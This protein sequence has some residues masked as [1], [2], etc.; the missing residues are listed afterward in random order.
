MRAPSPLRRVAGTTILS[1]AL[2]L[3]IA[4]PSNGAPSTSPV[5]P[6]SPRGAAHVSDTFSRA[7]AALRQAAA[8]ARSARAAASAADRSARVAERRAARLRTAAARQAASLS[9]KRAD[10]LARSARIAADRA[11]HA[12]AVA[13]G[14][15]RPS[16]GSLPVIPAAALPSVDA[17][18]PVVP[19]PPPGVLPP[20]APE[21]APTSMPTSTATAT[22][23]A[24]PSASPPAAPAQPAPTVGVSVLAFGAVGDG[25]ADDTAAVQRALDA[26]RPGVAVVVPAGRVFVHTDVL[27]VRVPGT[28]VTG[29]GVLLAT[30][31]DRSSVW[32]EADGVTLDGLTV[33]T[34]GTTRRW[35]AWEQMGLRLAGHSGAVVREVT[36]EGSAAAG[37]YVG[38]ADH[39]L[40]DHVTVQ[41]TRADGIHLTEGSHDGLVLAPTVVGSGDDG[42]AV[43]SY[44]SDGAPCHDIVVRSPQVLGTTWGRGLSVVGGTDVAFT[45]V[46]VQRSDAAAVYLGSEGQ[47]WNTWAPVRVSVTGG[48][49]QDSN[50]DQRID[51]GAVLVLAGGDGAPA[52][53]TV[54]VRGL[55]ISGTRR[56]ASRSAG[57]ISYGAAPQRVLLDQLAITGGPGDPVNGNTG[58]YTSTAI[59]KDGRTM[60]DHRG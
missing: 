47:P 56:T 10:A 15:R 34:Q 5:S 32:V 57:V 35:E 7:D 28:V 43:V 48:R 39:F 49:L 21:P 55:S 2:L 13:A 37:L 31:E 12:A 52:P 19:L 22:S 27:H 46:D 58:S 26:A 9:R 6:A 60:P 44:R 33:R 14:A 41:G 40:L 4:G 16:Q 54:T 23:T 45:D 24:A 20:L 11:S 42:V 53:D 29:G 51:H 36:V 30:R 18:A 59:T 17:V 38:G 50:T 25:A 3:A 1:A 8:A